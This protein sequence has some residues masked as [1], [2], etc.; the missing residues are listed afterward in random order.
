MCGLATGAYESVKDIESRIDRTKLITYDPSSKKD[1]E[2][3]IAQWQDAV[4]RCL[5]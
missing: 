3:L 1:C 2:K 5:K 4:K